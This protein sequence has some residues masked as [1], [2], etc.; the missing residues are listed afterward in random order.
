MFSPVFWPKV[1]S[2]SATHSIGYTSRVTE[3]ESEEDDCRWD[4]VPSATR[5][6]GT[7]GATLHTARRAHIQA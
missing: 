1:K 3:R 6:C 7:A 2:D 5:R 4:V